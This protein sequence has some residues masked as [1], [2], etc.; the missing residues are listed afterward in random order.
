MRDN[1]KELLKV[2][3]K[4]ATYQKQALDILDKTS[5]QSANEENSANSIYGGIED[6]DGEN[7][8]LMKQAEPDKQKLEESTPDEELFTT[9][10][11]DDL[12]E[13]DENIEREDHAYNII[14]RIMY[15]IVLVGIPIFIYFYRSD[16]LYLISST[17]YLL[18]SIVC[19]VFFLCIGGKYLYSIKEDIS[20][21]VEIIARERRK[22]KKRKERYR[23]NNTHIPIHD[24]IQS[25]FW[26]IVKIFAYIFIFIFYIIK[27]ILLMAMFL[28]IYGFIYIVF[29]LIMSVLL[30]TAYHNLTITGI[31]LVAV[32]I[33]VLFCI[34][35][36][37]NKLF[38]KDYSE[39]KRR[40]KRRMRWEIDT[41]KQNWVDACFGIF[42]N[43]YFV[44]FLVVLVV[45]C[46]LA[47][48]CIK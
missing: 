9:P 20:K 31:G 47:K 18:S 28:I 27:I 29:W 45:A 48:L 46:I 34:V 33:I 1:V 19:S 10:P 2:T 14:N 41:L 38:L 44:F 39:T 40:F 13:N 16:N 36:A 32:G 17:I 3:S 30:D 35:K 5:I 24:R 43:A 22:D 7:N 42:K 25:I 26:D 6:I 11:D 4:E 8:L 23:K 37:I 15:L 21:T 12:Y